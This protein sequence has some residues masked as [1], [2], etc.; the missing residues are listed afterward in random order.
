MGINGS[1]LRV[2]IL[3]QFTS[4]LRVIVLMETQSSSVSVFQ[5][6]R[7]MGLSQD[8]VRRLMRQGNITT[9]LING[10][11]VLSQGSI[12]EYQARKQYSQYS[13]RDRSNISPGLG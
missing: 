9:Q 6:A 3:D 1:V 10:Q 8:D 11:R 13:K 2:F 5:A 4:I 12:R 7:S